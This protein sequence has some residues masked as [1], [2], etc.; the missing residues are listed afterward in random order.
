MAEFKVYGITVNYL[1][2][3]C[4]IDENPSFS[5]MLYTDKTVEEHKNVDIINFAEKKRRRILTKM[6]KL[7][8]LKSCLLN[9]KKK[10]R[11]MKNIGTKCFLI[12]G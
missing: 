3:P 10:T 11:N 9:V 2:N 4:G 1:K 5:V 12:M 7:L 6:S 8:V